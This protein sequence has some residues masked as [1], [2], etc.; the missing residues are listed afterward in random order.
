MIQ[1]SKLNPVR[2]IDTTDINAGFDGNFNLYQTPNYTDPKC[3]LQKWAQSDTL[4]LQVVAD[5]APSNVEIRDIDNKLIDTINWAASTL[6]LSNFPTLTIYE[7]QYQFS[8]CPVGKY[9]LY[10]DDFISEPICVQIDQTK[11]IL[12][13]YKNSENNYST[14]FDTGIE[15]EFRIESEIRGYKPKNDREVYNDQKQNLT[16]LFSVAY[17]QFTF[18]VGGQRG[19][20]RWALDKV[21]QIQQCDQVSYNGILYQPIADAEFEVIQPEFYD[22]LGATVDIQ[23]KDNNFSKFVT[24]PVNSGVT[25]TPVQ[26]VT[27]FSSGSGNQTISGVFKNLSFLEHLLIYKTGANYILN[28]GTTPGGNEIMA[29]AN[30]NQPE[31]V[32]EVDWPFTSTQDV[33][34]TGA[35]LNYNLMYALWK[36]VDEPPINIGSGT[37]APPV[38]KGAKMFFEELTAGDLALAF[39]LATGLGLANTDWADWC[40]AGTN[41]TQ[42][43]S[44][45]LPIGWDGADPITIGTP[46]GSATLLIAKTNLPAEGIATLSPTV[47]TS[48]GDLPD[49]NSSVARA[50]SNNGAFA[51]ELRKGSGPANLGKSAN[52][53]DGTPLANNPLSRVC[54]YVIKIN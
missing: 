32:L 54:V 22:L 24:Q 8:A 7:L 37:P 46:T 4:K 40:L 18:V 41:G 43:M 2:F 23:P 17:S 6:V 20:A 1:I 3:Y 48:P 11:T 30:I 29:N 38:G 49:A 36:Q 25:F 26:K 50:G 15:F 21:N 14:V 9:Q 33:Y 13:K 34:L 51:Y 35:G 44:G 28:I 42:D 16:Q 47:N 39:N 31:N 45:R 5:I 10:F 27:P 53:G 19:V 52:L 12:L